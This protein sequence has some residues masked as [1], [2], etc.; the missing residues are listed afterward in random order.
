MNEN[1]RDAWL[2]FK[3]KNSHKMI[4]KVAEQNMFDAFLAGWREA[5]TVAEKEHELTNQRWRS[6]SHQ[7]QEQS[8]DRG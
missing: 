5:G 6:G 7:A 8:K 3:L 2:R 1:F 4:N